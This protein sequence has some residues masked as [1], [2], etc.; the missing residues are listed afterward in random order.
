MKSNELRIGNYV[1]DKKDEIKK[2]HGVNDVVGVAYVNFENEFEKLINPEIS[3]IALTEEWILKFRFKRGN[4]NKLLFNIKYG[5]GMK[6][7]VFSSEDFEAFRVSKIPFYFIFNN[8]PHG[9]WHVHELQNLFFAL[10]GEE[11]TLNN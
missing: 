9:V 4:L 3:P 10:T 6:F 5:T 1:L 7:T 8:I 11:L 2:I